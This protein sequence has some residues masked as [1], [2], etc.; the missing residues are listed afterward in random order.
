MCGPSL[1][2]P[3]YC[4]SLMCS[5]VCQRMS[6]CWRMIGRA[7]PPPAPHCAVSSRKWVFLPISCLPLWPHS[8]TCAYLRAGERRERHFKFRRKQSPNSCIGGIGMSSDLCLIVLGRYGECRELVSGSENMAG[9]TRVLEGALG[10]AE[11]WGGGC[12]GCGGGGGGGGLDQATVTSDITTLS[13]PHLTHSWPSELRGHLDWLV[14][15]AGHFSDW[16]KSHIDGEVAWFIWLSTFSACRLNT[17][18]AV[19]P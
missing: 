11:G 5:G 13:S 15:M 10:C 7:P 4:S 8:Q 17:W 2:S 18:H 14:H 12:W 3:L 1:T 16:S 19:L 9:Q 6:L